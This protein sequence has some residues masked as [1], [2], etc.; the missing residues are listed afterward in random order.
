MK[1]DFPAIIQSNKY[2]PYLPNS[3]WFTTA[4]FLCHGS[5]GL[6]AMGCQ[7]DSGVLHMSLTPGPSLNM[8]A[9]VLADGGN[10]RVLD[11]TCHIS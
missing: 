6:T 2:V 10:A 4:T 9:L 1:L 3:N 11:L 7:A 8:Q 5:G